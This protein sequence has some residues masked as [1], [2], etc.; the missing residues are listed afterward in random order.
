MTD[1]TGF[2]LAGHLLEMMEASGT[3]AT[4]A[5]D[6]LPLL[7]G[8]EGL[9]AA[10]QASTLAPANRAAVAGRLKAAPGVDPADP[11][12]SLLFD[13]QTSGGLL[14]AVPAA[15][16]AGLVQAIVAGGLADAAVIGR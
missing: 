8:A 11:R 13:P 4:V 1:V 16:A 5:L 3:A 2:G 14:A 12:L 7:P 6:A 10:G 9:A 15:A